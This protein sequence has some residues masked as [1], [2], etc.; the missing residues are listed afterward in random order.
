[1]FGRR[2]VAPVTIVV[3]SIALSLFATETNKKTIAR[4]DSAKPSYELPQPDKESLDYQMYDS[5]RKE[6][7]SHSQIMEYASALM[8]GIG[9][10]LTGSPNLKR[11]NRWTQDQLSAMG[12]SNAH[13]EDWGEFGMGWQQLNTWMR[14]KSPDTA[15]FIVQA[16]P[17]SPATN[18]I[19][20]ASAMWLDIQDEKDFEKYKGKVTGKIVFLGDMREVKPIDKPLFSRYD[21][22][23]LGKIEEYPLKQEDTAAALQAGFKRLAFREKIGQ[24]LAA[25]GAIAVIRQSRDSANGGGSGGTIFDDNGGSFGRLFYKADHK[26]PIPSAI[27]AIES[28]GRVYRLL[29]ANVP[30][31]IELNIETK[32]TGDH[33]HGFNTIA[34][35]TG[36][37]P[38]LKDEV[39]MFGGHLDSWAAGTGATDNGAGT[40]VAIEVMRILSALHVKPRRTIRVALWTG[41]EV[42]HLGSVAYVAQHFGSIPRSTEPDQLQLPERNRKAVGPIQLKPEQEL[43]TGYFNLDSGGGK[44]RGVYL[45]ENARVAR[46]FEQWMEPLKDVGVTAL[47]LQNTGGTDHESFDAVGVPAFQFIQDPLDYDTRTHHSNMDTFERL[48]PGDLSQAAFVEAIFVYNAA[49]RDQLLP[50]KPFPHP[51]FDLKRSEPLKN[52]TPGAEPKK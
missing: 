40:V 51:E 15:V 43:I 25:E 20:S 7:L 10:R 39:V 37:D 33:E 9:P 23:D 18:G 24:F 41:E 22:T 2:I 36:T 13:L 31:T 5:I 11:A 44:I 32:F 34:E 1:M 27:I 35:I 38:K 6:A 14:M 28:Y 4:N 49:M 8:D 17:W 45:Q 3:V 47:T 29:K 48:Q 52:V 12:C 19:V 30:V 26:A 21:D 16:A 42:G 50:R 46:I